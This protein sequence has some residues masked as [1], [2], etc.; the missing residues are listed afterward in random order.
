MS[1]TARGSS[2]AGSA[3]RT[4]RRCRTRTS[5][6]ATRS[7]TASTSCSKRTR[8]RQ[9][10]ATAARS[11]TCASSSTA[12]EIDPVFFEKTY[13][14]GS[15]DDENAYRL[16]FEAL[17]KT[18]RAGIGRFSFHDREY[19]VAVRALDDVIVLHTLR[20]HDEVVGA[21]ISRS[22][23]AHKPSQKEVEMAVQLVGTL[24]ADVRPIRLSRTV[25]RRG[26]RPD[27]AQGQGEE[28]DLVAEEEPEQGDDLG[29]RSRRA[30]RERS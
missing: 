8:S 10:Q 24:A 23:P 29:P 11:S 26:A 25:P 22:R 1:R 7:P 14:V 9:R 15:R 4:T 30:S 2:T 3:R 21:T 19:L 17:K 28:I 18:G 6:R 27:Q 20:F 12:P 5:S 16:L 13:Y